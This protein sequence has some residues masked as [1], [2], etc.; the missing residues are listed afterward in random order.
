M[1]I[2]VALG[3]SYDGTLSHEAGFEPPRSYDGM[4]ERHLRKTMVIRFFD[5]NSVPSAMG[6]GHLAIKLPRW[7]KVEVGDL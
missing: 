3:P 1:R 4:R 7:F 6:G 5:R 2:T